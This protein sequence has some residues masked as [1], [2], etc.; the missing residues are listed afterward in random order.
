[1]PMDDQT[2]RKLN[3]INRTFYATVAD[4]FDATRQN[5]W[6]GWE[7]MLNTV[8]LSD[9]FSVL[10][11]GCGNGRFGLFLAEHLS[12][13]IHY[14]GID[15]N[16]VLL[17]TANSM[18]TQRAQLTANLIGADILK[19]LPVKEVYDLV[20]AFGLL[21]HVPGMQNRLAFVRKLAACVAGGGYLAFASWRFYEQARFRQR[22][23]P[24][25]PEL[26]DVVEANDY[27]L[28]WRRGTAALRYCHYIDDA[29]HGRLVNETGLQQLVTYRA[30]GKSE[31]LNAY[32]ILKRIP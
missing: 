29:E 2:I 18:L 30:D 14:T 17:Q 28:D 26:A 27:L 20:V 15:N 3:A 8:T 25:P 9:D 11:V 12:A 7:R 24:W 21:H 6:P 22:I 4:E 16:P 32:T 1:M 13:N 5:P 31:D 23:V 19:E 10:D